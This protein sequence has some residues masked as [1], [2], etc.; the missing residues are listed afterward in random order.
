M[1][2]YNAVRF[3]GPVLL[4]REYGELPSALSNS[5]FC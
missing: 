2:A 3:V 1:F 4:R 5:M